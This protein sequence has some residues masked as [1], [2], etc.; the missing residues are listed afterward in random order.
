MSRTFTCP[1]FHRFTA[2]GDAPLCPICGERGKVDGTTAAPGD[3][4]VMMSQD[5]ASSPGAL[6]ASNAR[7]G[8]FVIVRSH[9]RGGLG[10]V[11]V[12]HDPSL[13]RD[14]ALKQMRPEVADDVRSRHR[15]IN[16]AE[17]TGQL[18]HPGIVPVY[19][20]GHDSDGRPF[21][22]MKFVHGRTLADAIAE[23]HRKP[24]SHSLRELL[25]RFVSVCQA[26][27]YAHSKGVIHRDLKP[28]NIMLGEFGEQLIL[29][30]GLAKRLHDD[31]HRVEPASARGSL[32]DG[33][34]AAQATLEGQV[35]G[36]PMYMSPE[37]ATGDV[38]KQNAATDVYSLGAI[39]YHIL[40][41]Q[42]ALHGHTNEQIVTKLKSNESLPPPRAINRNVD[43]ALEAICI[44]A[45]STDLNDRY[46]TAAELA[47]EIDHWAGDEPVRAYREPLI[48]RAARLTR[49]HR[50]IVV[51]GAAVIAVLL[52]GVIGTS[53]QTVRATRAQHQADAQ[54]ALAE[55]RFG[56]VRVLANQFMFDFHKQIE[57]LAGSTPAVKMLVATA[58]DYL[59]KLA[60]DAGDD[61]SL[62]L[63]LAT[64]YEKVGD[65]QGNPNVGSN[66]GD[67]RGALASYR[68]ALDLHRK[69]KSL[70]RSVRA[71][72]E[73]TLLSRIG[74]VLQAQG[75]TKAAID[76]YQA[77]LATFASLATTQ[78]S[79]RQL[80]RD[81]CVSNARIGELL[82]IQ[83][84]T[85]GAMSAL[86]ESWRIAKQLAEDKSDQ[87]AQIDQVG[88]AERVADLYLATGKA[89]EARKI[90]E[91]TL[92]VV[93][94]AAERDPNNARYQTAL[95][96]TYTL[97]GTANLAGDDATAARES[98]DA[99]LKIARALAAKDPADVNA[100]QNLVVIHNRIGDLLQSQEDVEGALSQFRAMLEV[101]ERNSARDPA[102]AAWRRHCAVCHQRIA[103]ILHRTDRRDE[104][105]AHYRA[106]LELIK[107]I[108][109]NDPTNAD[110][111]RDLWVSYGNVAELLGAAGMSKSL[112]P[113]Q[114]ST[115]LAEARGYYAAALT[116]LERPDVAYT[117]VAGDE[118]IIAEY[119]DAIVECDALLL[120]LSPPRK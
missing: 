114:R 42:P 116:V 67:T 117:K 95:Q 6:S 107:T 20:I 44:K 85:E 5:A 3:V 120:K 14:V 56:E 87:R 76:S 10:L 101:C 43:R 15:F 11:S 45:M 31:S 52:L 16:E 88:P 33:G 21:Y 70:G 30:W 100:Q 47:D 61:P 23:H 104:A 41:G 8:S 34:S 71:R 96:R 80:Q 103:D 58:Q 26:I 81:L 91:Q 48:A 17:I 4:S 12:A 32:L 13:N 24:T 64:A 50:S 74:D 62:L 9:A 79:D 25:R 112:P 63:E 49:R 83:G 39:L 37:Q 78:P 86:E 119:R 68:K 99:A 22:A 46:S 113:E 28:S 110:A 93:Q 35:L 84:D 7:V 19:A 82:R 102:S 18:E 72:A 55:K 106:C 108:A 105:M 65:I 51:G 54:R 77:G 59:S 89:D 66:L 90:L 1:N 94:F 57:N 29:D 98:F 53:I 38:A 115:L 97:M 2:E 75:D 36:T 92:Q 73:P 27:A 40:A 69:L 118:G 109:Q 60:S 111:Q